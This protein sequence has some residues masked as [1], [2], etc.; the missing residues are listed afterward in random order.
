[1]RIMA[2]NQIWAPIIAT[3]KKMNKDLNMYQPKNNRSKKNQ[4]SNPQKRSRKQKRLPNKEHWNLF[5]KIRIFDHLNRTLIKSIIKLLKLLILTLFLFLHLSMSSQ[6]QQAVQQQSAKSDS[7]SKEDEHNDSV[8]SI[9]SL[10]N[11]RDSPSLPAKMSRKFQS[12]N[13]PA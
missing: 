10:T 9:N 4:S 6:I 12:S 2:S 8:H 11:K 3:G 7:G 5:N 13:V 1:M